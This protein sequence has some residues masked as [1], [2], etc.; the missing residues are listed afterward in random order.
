MRYPNQAMY[1]RTVYWEWKSPQKAGLMLLKFPV[2]EL[3]FSAGLV[4]SAV[5]VL[6]MMVLAAAKSMVLGG[7]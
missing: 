2:T 5:M 4:K 3:I 7:V 1:A 6:V